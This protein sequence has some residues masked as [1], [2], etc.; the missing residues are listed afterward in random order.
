MNVEQFQTEGCGEQCEGCG[1]RVYGKAL[2]IPRLSG[3]HCSVACVETRLF[4]D[5]HCRWCA[6]EMDTPYTSIN[7]RLCS[8]DC[9]E[10]YRAHV[11][12]DRTAALGTGRRL[13]LW[14]TAAQQSV[15][16]LVRRV[17]TPAMLAGLEKARAR[18]LGLENPA[19]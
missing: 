17:V 2:S 4:G 7:S 11:V 8:D 16:K 10:N 18:R 14:L 6:A 13:G 12:G 15:K 1:L 19:V 9:A 5:R 3:I